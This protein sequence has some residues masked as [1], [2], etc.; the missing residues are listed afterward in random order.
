[1]SALLRAHNAHADLVTQSLEA[2]LQVTQL[3]RT[4]LLQCASGVWL[5]APLVKQ[6]EV[7][8]ALCAWDVSTTTLL[9]ISLAA[10]V[11]SL[12]DCT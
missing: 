7:Q 1:M 5:E 10:P 8:S 4:I 12:H 3:R 6:N 9:G 2:G 11:L